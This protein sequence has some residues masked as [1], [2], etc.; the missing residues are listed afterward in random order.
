[1]YEVKL[2]FFYFFLKQGGVRD[3]YH[4]NPRVFLDLVYGGFDFAPLRNLTLI[5]F[6]SFER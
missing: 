4:F 6:L 3:K 5:P 2:T 1:M